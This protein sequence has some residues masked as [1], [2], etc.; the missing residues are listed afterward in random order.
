[1]KNTIVLMAC[2]DV[3]PVHGDMADY[4]TLVAPTFDTA[5]IRFAQCERLYTQSARL[6]GDG[7]DGNYDVGHGP[8]PA[9]MISVF[10]SAGFDVVSLAGNH[11]MEFGADAAVETAALFEAKGIRVVGFGRDVEEA[12]APVIVERD[13]VS[14]AFLAYCSVVREGHEATDER[15]GVAPMRARTEYR[16]VEWQPGMPMW[17]ITEPHEEDVARMAAGI[18][19]ARTRADAVVVSLHWGLHYIPRVIADYQ[20]VVAGAAFAAGADMILGHHPHVPKAIE[21]FG[22][23]SACFYSLGNFMFS[24]NTGRKPGFID[25]MRRYGVAADLD[26]YPHCP[27]GEDSHHSLIVKAAVSA[28]GV[29]RVSFLPVQIGPDLRPEVLSVG[30]PRFARNVGFM[31]WVS[32]GFDHRFES[33]GDEV[34]VTPSGVGAPV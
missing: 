33:E 20:P 31:D 15:P 11:T 14:V 30:D 5:D 34:V 25:K 19:D 29:E 21:M 10:T 12:C 9:E 18:A 22:E 32:Q 4:P 27:H 13:G 17:A 24:T 7:Y 6:E 2:G 8:L 1:V 16:Q 28:D 26:E 3:G 23:T